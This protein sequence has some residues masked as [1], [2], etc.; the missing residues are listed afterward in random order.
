M[1]L[2]NIGWGPVKWI[3]LAQEREEIWGFMDT[4]TYFWVL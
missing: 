1:D 2:K 3:Y 4:V